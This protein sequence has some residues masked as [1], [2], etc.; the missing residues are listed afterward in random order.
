ML[1]IKCR[2][3]LLTNRVTRKLQMILLLVTESNDNADK[4]N[5][6]LQSVKFLEISVEH[7]ITTY[8]FNLVYAVRSSV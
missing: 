3:L 8:L 7:A 6:F 5:G 1:V 4:K 2:I